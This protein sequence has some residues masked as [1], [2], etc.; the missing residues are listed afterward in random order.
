MALALIICLS[1]LPVASAVAAG[2]PVPNIPDASQNDGVYVTVNPV[3]LPEGYKPFIESYGDILS[4]GLLLVYKSEAVMD[5]HG[6]PSGS[7][8]LINFVDSRGSALYFR[9]GKYQ[10]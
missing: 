2:Y 10:R 9:R 7:K 4:D 3:R 6:Y 5:S 1:L 8:T